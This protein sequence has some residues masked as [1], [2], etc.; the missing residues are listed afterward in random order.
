MI[1]TGTIFRAFIVTTI[2]SFTLTGCSNDEE[3]TPAPENP[4]TGNTWDQ[5]EWDKGTW[6]N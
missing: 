1:N 2:L 5:M 4:A 6:A 3:S